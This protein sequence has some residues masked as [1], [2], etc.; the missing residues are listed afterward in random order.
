MNTILKDNKY[1]LGIFLSIFLIYFP[2]KNFS[3][4]SFVEYLTN[5]ESSYILYSII[6]LIFV[7]YIRTIRWGYLFKNQPNRNILYKAQFIGYFGNNVLPLRLGE[8]LRAFYVGEK[9]NKSK[10]KVIGTIVLERIFDLFGCG[11][12]FLIIINTTLFDV[13][14]SEYIYAIIL[15]NII[16]IAL[17]CFALT[18][19]YE[20]KEKTN[21]SIKKIIKD[22]IIGI[23]NIRKDNLLPVILTTIVIWLLYA[24]EVYFVQSAFNLN[25]SII[26]CIIILLISS[27]SMMIPAMPGNFGTFE[28]SV[29]YT[30]SLFNIVDNFGF[31]F[32]LHIVSYI[33]YT[34]IGFMYF[35]EDFNYKNMRN[36]IN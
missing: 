19:K 31:S 18:L 10:S 16:S 27:I 11:F 8:L 20:I 13:L 23:S 6:I 22:V 30:L 17:V 28:S 35:L 21:S 14:A 12:L 7:V 33:P 4:L 3:Y 2:I 26:Q 15:I 1:Y 32:I 5:L 9:E 36:I 29:I 34:F 25:L 24:L